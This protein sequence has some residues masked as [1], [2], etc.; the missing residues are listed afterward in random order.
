MTADHTTVIQ[1]APCDAGLCGE[2]VGIHLKHR[3]DPMPQDW[4]GPA[5]MRADHHPDRAGDQFNR[6]HRLERLCP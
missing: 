3:G 1:I 6:K 5:A 4:Q 2:I